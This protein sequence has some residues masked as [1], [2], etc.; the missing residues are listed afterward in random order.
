MRF[1]ME[2]LKKVDKHMSK[3]EFVCMPCDETRSG[4]F[5]PDFGVLLCQNRLG[6]KTHQEHTMVHEMIHMYDHHK[7]NVDWN[8]LK[9][10]ACSEVSFTKKKKNGIFNFFC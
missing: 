4:G 8:N 7:F 10:Q 2:Q 5:S 6:S 9:H 3:E 1:M